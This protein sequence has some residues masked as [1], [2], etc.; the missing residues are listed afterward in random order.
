M[1]QGSISGLVKKI[2]ADSST[3]RAQPYNVRDDGINIVL[4]QGWGEESN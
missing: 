4:T 3:G 2:T 1:S